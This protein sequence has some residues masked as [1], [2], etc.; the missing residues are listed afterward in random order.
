[1]QGIYIVKQ[2]ITKLKVDI[3]VNAANEWL[4]A[5]GGVCGAIFHA[6][7]TIRLT[8]ACK[9]I[10][11]CSTGDVAITPAF[12]LKAKNIIHAV[13]PIWKGGNNGEAEQLC[14]CYAKSLDLMR[15]KQYNSIA[16]P[17]ISAGIFG[18]PVEKAWEIAICACHN[19]IK[20]H[21][22]TQVEIVFAV[23]DENIYEMGNKILSEKM[24]EK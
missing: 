3:V 18:Y 9:A 13:G 23:I 21:P 14:S 12:Q 7:G 19:Y 6:A 4:K 2:D 11:H 8:R 10:G 15:E 16:F 20:E 17:L 1:M 22:D 24:D 5:G